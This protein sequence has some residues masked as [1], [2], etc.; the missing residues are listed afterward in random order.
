[1]ILVTKQTDV[2][3]IVRI[4]K[5][6][7]H[8]YL[9]AALLSLDRNGSVTL[10][11]LGRWNGKVLSVADMLRGNDNL[12]VSDPEFFVIDGTEGVRVVVSQG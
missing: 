1:M 4:G 3:D 2:S 11:G 8:D 12:R 7:E 6:G 5:K 9:G 10:E